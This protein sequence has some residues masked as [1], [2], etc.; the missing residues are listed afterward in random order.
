MA[1][2]K[3]I[4]EGSGL[5]YPAT[6]AYKQWVH[7]ELQ[8]RDWTFEEFATRLKR[9]GAPATTSSATIS[10][11]FFGRLKDETKPMAPSNTTLM[12]LMNKVLGIAP[13]PVCDPTSELAQ[14][15]DRVVAKYNSLSPREQRLVR[16]IFAD[17]AAS[18]GAADSSTIRG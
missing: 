14:L 8:R 2:R 7:A 12:P 10:Q 5:S 3:P 13:P 4:A 11:F 15:R 6:T 17:D 18:D 1:K 9:V 16:D